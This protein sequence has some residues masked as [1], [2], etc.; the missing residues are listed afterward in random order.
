MPASVLL[1]DSNRDELDMYVTALALEGIV[2]AT[3][4][5]AD[6]ALDVLAQT[7]ARALVTELRLPGTDGAEL[8]DRVRQTRPSTFIIALTTSE[9]LGTR[10]ARNAGCDVILHVPCAPETLVGEVRRGLAFLPDQAYNPE[11]S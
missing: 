7:H 6:E 11:L 4:G 2:S 8:I 9:G 3:A 10:R 1:V 5:S